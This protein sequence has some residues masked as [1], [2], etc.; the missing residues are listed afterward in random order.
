MIKAEP[1]RATVM[2]GL[3]RHPL[4]SVRYDSGCRV[5]PGMTEKRRHILNDAIVSF[6]RMTLGK[7]FT[8]LYYQY[9]CLRKARS[10]FS[11]RLHGKGI[12]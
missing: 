6:A 2:P 9:F 4:F 11:D 12:T 7:F 1:F 8:R 5:K 10:R 3:T